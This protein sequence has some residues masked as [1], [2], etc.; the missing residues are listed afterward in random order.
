MAEVC[1]DRHFAHRQENDEISATNGEGIVLV[2]IASRY[3]QIND[4]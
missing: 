2:D 1:E 4:V 3:F